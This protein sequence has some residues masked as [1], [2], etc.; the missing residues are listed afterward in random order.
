MAVPLCHPADGHE[1]EEGTQAYRLADNYLAPPSGS[2]APEDIQPPQHGVVPN[3]ATAVPFELAGY[4]TTA[5]APRL[6][7]GGAEGCRTWDM[8]RWRVRAPHL[9]RGGAEGA[10]AAPGEVLGR[11]GRHRA[12]GR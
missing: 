8:G 1:M 10:G 11:G 5:P 4:D 7:M 6:G 9:G 12:S 3:Q 2:A